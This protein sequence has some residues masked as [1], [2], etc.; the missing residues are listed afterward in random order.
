MNCDNIKKEI[1]LSTVTKSNLGT[2]IIEH[3]KT[4][5]DCSAYLESEKSLAKTISDEFKS[6]PI[7]IPNAGSLLNKEKP[8]RMIPWFIPLLSAS[9]AIMLIAITIFVFI[10]HNRA[11]NL[12]NQ[13]DNDINTNPAEVQKFELNDGTSI[14]ASPN[15]KVV[16]NET[17]RQVILKQSC[18]LYLKVEENQNKP[19]QIIT[20]AGNIIV[21]GTEFSVKVN[22]LEKNGQLN[23]G[24]FSV[25]VYVLNGTVEL[26]TPIGNVVGNSGYTL[27]AEDG[28]APVRNYSW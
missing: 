11:N 19:F 27:Y 4:C 12:V 23:K 25:L 17:E 18:D 22:E 15:C 16:I 1:E 9:A 8:R 3:I 24:I 26:T 13:A 14:I 20:P 28:L 7:I 10:N 5:S 2:E 21:R 6:I